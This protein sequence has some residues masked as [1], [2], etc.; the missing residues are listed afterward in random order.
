MISTFMLKRIFI[1]TIFSIVYLFPSF[2][3]DL[4]YLRY[5]QNN[6]EVKIIKITADSLFFISAVSTIKVTLDQVIAYKQD[7]RDTSS[8]WIYPN[9]EDAV[10]YPVYKKYICN[11][12]E[13]W[14]MDSVLIKYKIDSSFLNSKEF[15]FSLKNELKGKEKTIA[16]DKGKKVVLLLNSDP[17]NRKLPLKLYGISQDALLV[18]DKKGGTNYYWIIP[19][20]EIETLGFEQKGIAI[21]RISYATL[22]LPLAPISVTFYAMRFNRNFKIEKGWQIVPV[23]TNF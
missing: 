18:S 17:T 3:Q 2:T 22:T 10:N 7:M 5:D 13:L 15:S 14:N 4:I 6:Y 12:Y 1:I 20:E 19:I 16:R 21:L 23:K 9:P 11:W 8:K